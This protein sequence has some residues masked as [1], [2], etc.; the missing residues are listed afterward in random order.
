LGL[1]RIEKLYWEGEFDQA[2]SLIEQLQPKDSLKGMMF[3]SG[4]LNIR[5]L[6]QNALDL[7]SDALQQS[8]ET[9]EHTT[10]LMALFFYLWAL[11]FLGRYED[12]LESEKEILEIGHVDE[13]NKSEQLQK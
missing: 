2:L 11:L 6:Y 7:A 1:A 10:R 4:I 5:G 9:N 3:K 8:K 12:F 13:D